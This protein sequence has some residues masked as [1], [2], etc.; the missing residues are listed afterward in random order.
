MTAGSSQS[1]NKE[2]AR[3]FYQEE[4]YSEAIR[5]YDKLIDDATLDNPEIHIFYSNR[6][7]AYMQIGDANKALEDA[8]QCK[9]LKPVW[10]KGYSRCGSALI[11]LGRFRE[12]V[13]ALEK[14]QELE[15]TSTGAALLNQARQRAGM[16]SNYQDGANGGST[17]GINFG[18]VFSSVLDQVKGIISQ[19]MGN[20]VLLSPEY[21]LAAGGIALLIVYKCYTWLFSNPD[22]YYDDYYYDSRP[23]YGLSW[24]NWAMIMGAAWK[25][26]PMFPDVFGQY[27]RPFF[28]M[29]FTTFMYLLNMLTA[30]QRFGGGGGMFG[31]GRRRRW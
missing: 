16:S 20:F 2:A 7:A 23:S 12:A 5:E 1:P 21:R 3:K 19:I 18:S 15:P 29:S 17:G 30:G 4:R 8:E 13:Y 9:R 11:A 28:G 27:A 10:S 6:S 26:P 22:Y 24:T 14:S 31:G 25:L